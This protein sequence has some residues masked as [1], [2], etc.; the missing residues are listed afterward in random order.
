[1]VYLDNAAT[2]LIKPEEVYIRSNEVFRYLSA[3]PGRSGHKP[4]L[5]AAEAV[6]S[7]R[8]AAASFLGI[9]KIENVIFT[10]GC[11]DSLN[12][13]IKGIFKKGDH[14]IASAYEHNSVLRPLEYMKNTNGVEY[15][16]VFPEKKGALELNDIQKNL[17]QNTKAIILNYVSNVTGI[18]QDAEKIGAF[19][20]KNKLLFI[21]DCAQAAGTKE[22]NAQKMHIDYVCCAGHKGL[23][24]PQGIGLLG[25]NENAPL[26]LP[27]RLGGTGSRSF[28]LTQPQEMPEYL[29]SGTLATQNIA[30][31]EAGIKFVLRNKN[32]D[33]YEIFLANTLINGLK[34]IKGITVYS[35]ESAQ[36]GVVAFNILN[37]DS[38]LVATLLD[39]EY[40]IACRGGFHC[41]PMV[42]KLLNTQNTGAVRFS[43]GAF[44]K[45]RDALYAIEAVNKTA[46]S[47]KR[48]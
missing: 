28:E 12:M 20:Q 18:K 42:H 36:S 33:E 40:G 41:A 24:G 16:V 19:C 4:S 26:P 10:F 34:N 35:P 47:L 23:Y 21:L 32:I 11:T 3:N 45:K 14:V 37:T 15:T 1:M 5:A 7:A 9:N 38:S 13:V 25:I 8:A 29:E 17:K 6:M 46:A 48:L 27:L 31:L 44:N 22:I 2:T 43:F 30:A 39:K